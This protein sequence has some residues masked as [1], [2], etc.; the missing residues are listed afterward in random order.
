MAKYKSEKS[1]Q[2]YI[3][4]DI[5]N[6]I[7]MG[8]LKPC[9]KILS[10]KDLAK[11][12]ALSRVTVEK[13]METLSE[14][15][16]ITLKPKTGT[17]VSENIPKNYNKTISILTSFIY[18]KHDIE[19]NY[20]ILTMKI[21]PLIVQKI[22]EKLAEKKY[23]SKLCLYYDDYDIQKQFINELG[24]GEVDGIFCL[25]MQ[26]TSPL[27]K[28]AEREMPVIML[29]TFDSRLRLPAITTGNYGAAYRLV[30]DIL[31]RRN[32]ENIICIS[33]GILATSIT[34]REMGYKVSM[35]D[36][37]MHAE[38]FSVNTNDIIINKKEESLHFDMITKKI[39]EQSKNQKTA[40]ISTIP[41]LHKIFWI[42]CKKKNYPVSNVTWCSFDDPF[43]E[44][45]DDVKHVEVIQDFDTIAQ[46][47]TEKM[48]NIIN[49]KDDN[50]TNI[51]YVKANIRLS[52]KL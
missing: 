13:A 47:A 2:D 50:Y 38:I 46:K 14:K 11:E 9:E 45:P 15:G 3:A 16:Y 12:Y 7:N 33:S 27:K 26:D 35:N 28:Y 4:R 29:D 43:I 21:A 40:I 41:D 42:Y 22:Q 44:Y 30:S 1:K 51:E 8:I 39:F 34:D 48:V 24:S 25:N 32:Y 17:F 19:S 31:I 49:N 37:N 10:R 6:K 5:I 18:S 20:Q 52:R 36:N 23:M